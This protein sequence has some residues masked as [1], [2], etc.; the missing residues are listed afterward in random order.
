[1]LI[2][3]AR[4]AGQKIAFFFRLE[5]RAQTKP[6]RVG[7][8]ARGLLRL[9]LVSLAWDGLVDSQISAAHGHDHLP[10]QISPAAK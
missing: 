1:M 4:R 10:D 5:Q 7:D 6:T 3:N 9:D 8:T 2:I